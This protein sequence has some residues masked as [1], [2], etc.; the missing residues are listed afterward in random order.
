MSTVIHNDYELN[1]LA[2]EYAQMII[3]EERENNPEDF[4]DYLETYGDDKVWE[5]AD[6]SEHIIYTYKAHAICQNCN[7]NEAEAIFGE[8]HDGSFLTYDELAAH[9]AFLELKT[10]TR[11]ALANL[12]ADL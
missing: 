11:V 2:Y 1:Q 3:D 12:I 8:Y 10:R 5:F 9:L 7:I 6:N 4:K